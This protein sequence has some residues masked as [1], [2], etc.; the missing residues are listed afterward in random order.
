MKI[1]VIGPTQSGKTCL[2]VGLFSTS[3]RGFTIDVPDDKARNYLKERRK[4]IVQGHWPDPTNVGTSEDLRFDF[5]KRHRPDVRVEFTEFA[6]E[7]LQDEESFKRFA[8]RHFTELD[9]VVLLVNPGADA[10]QSGDPALLEDAKTQYH[11][12]LSFLH[13]PNNNSARAFVALTVTA[14]D[15]IRGVRAELRGRDAAFRDCLEEIENSLSAMEFRWSGKPFY[16]SMSGRTGSGNRFE[17]KA[18][19]KGWPNTTSRPFLWILDRLGWQTAS[20]FPLRSR[21]GRLAAAL[22]LLAAGAWCLLRSEG[23]HAEIESRYKDALATLEDPGTTPGALKRAFDNANANLVWLKRYNGTFY[24]KHAEKRY[25]ELEPKASDVLCAWIE[26]ECEDLRAGAEERASI[27]AVAQVDG[28]F[29]RL[30]P[31]DPES[32]NRL[33]RLQSSWNAE[34]PALRERFVGMQIAGRLERPL[35]DLVGRHDESSLAALR[36]LYAE[37]RQLAATALSSNLIARLGAFSVK[38]DGQT[39]EEWRDWVVPSFSA[40]ASTNATDKAVR[41]FCERLAAWEPLTP[42]GRAAQSNLLERVGASIPEWR[43][44]YETNRLFA[45]ATAAVQNHNMAE[46]AKCFPGNVPANEF[47]PEEFVQFLWTNK[48]EGVVNAARDR[49]HEDLLE[50]IRSRH[51]RPRLTNDDRARIRRE[52]EAINCPELLDFQTTIDTIRRLADQEANAWDAQRRDEYDSWVRENITGVRKDRKGTDLLRAY[53]RERDRVHRL[54]AGRDGEAVFNEIVRSAVYRHV[55]RCLSED[56]KYFTSHTTAEN[57]ARFND[58]FKPLC[59]TIVEDAEDPDSASWAVRFAKLCIDVGRIKDGF[60]N[61]FPEKFEITRIRGQI[62]YG[63]EDPWEWGWAWT[64]IGFRIRNGD[65]QTVLVSPDKDKE[66][67]I[68]EEKYAEKD[69]WKQLWQGSTTVTSHLFDPAILEISVYDH[70]RRGASTR[71][72]WDEPHPQFVFP[73]R[74]FGPCIVPGDGE[75]PGK[76]QFG[77]PFGN[78]SD[79]TMEA[80]VLVNI[81]RIEGKTVGEL[82]AEA[83][84]EDAGGQ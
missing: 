46:L 29:K 62:P 33:A 8:N 42:A 65:Q 22:V 13:D 31:S 64:Q 69:N 19:P 48:V 73:L 27:E 71:V 78:A 18:V 84:G 75:S 57:E 74:S 83:K 56:L 61:A 26:R 1:A 49:F 5:H 41:V 51:G 11:R 59:K 47:L 2:A 81:R 82:L 4:E 14:A 55:E 30:Q 79:R 10:F 54:D 58:F 25:V 3:S 44:A 16:I 34:K 37:H 38:L 28:L 63:G 9:G 80:Y 21:T 17:K 53:M 52:I 43:T 67:V 70:R 12:I 15:R 6:G 40:A 36:N 68:A 7:R 20:H 35:A 76:I 32:S 45:A 66:S 23:D 77:G 50:G 39:A 60:G 24:G 72:E